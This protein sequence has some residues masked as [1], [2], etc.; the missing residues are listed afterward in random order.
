L[1]ATQFKDIHHRSIR[2]SIPF[3]DLVDAL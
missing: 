3:D 1:N 2:D